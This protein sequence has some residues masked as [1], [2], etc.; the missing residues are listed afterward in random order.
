M[1]PMVIGENFDL[2]CFEVEDSPK[3]RNTRREWE[4]PDALEKCCCNSI[5]LRMGGKKPELF[6]TSGGH[7]LQDRFNREIVYIF[8]CNLCR[9]F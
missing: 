7:A 1:G 4:L 6:S 5:M 9:Y 3:N 8:R 2:V